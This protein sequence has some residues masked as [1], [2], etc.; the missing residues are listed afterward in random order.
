MFFGIQKWYS[1]NHRNRI[2]VNQMRAAIYTRTSTAKQ[3]TDSQMK[4]LLELVERAG[5]ELI[6]TIEDVGVSGGKKGRQREGMKRVMEM[7]NRREIDLLITYSVDRIGRHMGDVISLVEELDEKG[8]GLV[9][10]KNGVDTSTTYGKTLVSFFALV[11][12]MERD[13]IRSRV[14]DGMAAAKE[15]GRLPGRKK[16]SKIKE[17]QILELLRSGKGKVSIGKQLGVGISTIYRVEKE[18]QIA[19]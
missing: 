11:A 14:K 3:S 18:N 9:I 1:V 12:Q 5:Y 15:K 8:V 2:G 13:F 7:V 16:I 6:D 10:H 17:Q 4:P 19:A